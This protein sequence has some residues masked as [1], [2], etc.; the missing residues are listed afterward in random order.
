MI[1]AD[2]R[3]LVYGQNF[4][5]DL[6]K[7]ETNVMTDNI[8]DQ[9]NLPGFQGIVYPDH[10]DLLIK[11][12]ASMN[13][14]IHQLINDTRATNQILPIPIN[15]RPVNKIITRTEIASAVLRDTGQ[16]VPSFEISVQCGT[17]SATEA[18]LSFGKK[19][20]TNMVRINALD[21]ETKAS[22]TARQ[23]IV[24]GCKELASW[25]LNEAYDPNLIEDDAIYLRL[26]NTELT[27][28]VNEAVQMTVRT[29]LFMDSFMN[30][31]SDLLDL[32][33]REG[34]ASAEAHFDNLITMPKSRL[35][36]ELPL[37]EGT[38]VPIGRLIML[39][40]N[41]SAKDMEFLELGTGPVMLTRSTHP[42]LLKV[43]S[44]LEKAYDIPRLLL[45]LKDDT[46]MCYRGIEA[47]GTWTVKRV[48]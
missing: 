3:C 32:L 41:K 5:S 34:F 22:Q 26:L 31:Y 4:T 45:I 46:L 48:C 33:E 40:V 39:R 15:P 1:D 7:K 42:T 12:A 38:L 24:R 35:D 17:F 43:M 21:I 28:V 29:T 13:R 6:P 37:S 27:K 36:V 44:S 20:G 25:M 23:I 30:D 18:R 47:T 14:D 2:I 8:Q 19:E 11:E 9:S 10:I 16:W